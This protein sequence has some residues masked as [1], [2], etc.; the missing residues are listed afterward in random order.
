MLVW[1]FAGFGALGMVLGTYFLTTLSPERL[2]KALWTT[3][4]LFVAFKILNPQW[5]LLRHVGIKIAPITGFLA[6]GLQGFTG[7]SAPISLPFL[8]AM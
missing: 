1:G 5:T 3:V 4:L 6:G 8:N 2:E 7:L